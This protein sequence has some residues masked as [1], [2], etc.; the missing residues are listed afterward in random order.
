MFLERY[1][2]FNQKFQL[3]ELVCDDQ[4]LFP[5]RYSPHFGCKYA[6]HYLWVPALGRYYRD[7][8]GR[9]ILTTSVLWSIATCL[10]L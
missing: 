3:V 8:Y 10:R 9:G 4:L 2:L 7:R 5:Q 1:R 6:F